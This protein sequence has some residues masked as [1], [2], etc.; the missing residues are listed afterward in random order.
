MAKSTAGGHAQSGA[1]IGESGSGTDSAA[2]HGVVDC[3]RFLLWLGKRDNG[4][5]LHGRLLG[6]DGI[7]AESP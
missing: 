4:G 3:G 5:L 6:G 2:D 7:A 1:S